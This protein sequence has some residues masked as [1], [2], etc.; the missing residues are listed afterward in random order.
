MRDR[1]SSWRRMVRFLGLLL[2]FTAAACNGGP[3]GPS[4]D[5]LIALYTGTWRGNIN[6]LDVILNVRAMPSRTDLG[7]EFDGSGTT[8]F[9]TGE[10]HHL[11]IEGGTLGSGFGAGFGLGLAGGE[12]GRD[13]VSTGH[14]NGEVSRDGRTWPGRFTSVMGQGGE[15][16][17]GPGEHSVTLTK[18]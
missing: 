1:N 16:I 4:T 2:A 3:T 13:V 18:D 14:F 6:G 7:L 8:R 10:W 9:A 17:F 11:W 15:P 5:E 12:T